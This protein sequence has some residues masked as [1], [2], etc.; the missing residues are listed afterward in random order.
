M[1]TRYILLG[2]DDCI[3]KEKRCPYNGIYKEIAEEVSEEVAVIM[4][5]HYKGMQITFPVR[6]YSAQYVKEK[7]RT[8]N[9]TADYRTL[10]REYGYSERWLRQMMKED[11]NV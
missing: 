6:L 3:S 2:R 4:H 1:N 9:G 11:E 8:C 5:E 10:A 7:L